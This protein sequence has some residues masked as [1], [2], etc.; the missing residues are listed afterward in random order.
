MIQVFSNKKQKPHHYGFMELDKGYDPYAVGFNPVE[1]SISDDGVNWRSMYDLPELEGIY[2]V[3][4]P[5]V[6]PAKQT[7]EYQKVGI[8]D[9][10]SLLSSSYDQREIQAK[11]SFHGIDAND[12]KLAFDVLQRFFVRRSCYWICFDSWP[13]RMYYVK[14]STIEQDSLT[15]Q[16]FAVTITFVD[17]IG[18][19]RSV[20]TTGD[21]DNRVVGFGNN[22]T[23]PE[24]YSF[25]TNNF[26]VDNL[27]DVLI[28]PERRGHPLKITV[29]GSSSGKFKLTNK[30]T[31]DSISRDKGFSGTFVL[32]GV[33]PTLNGQGD[34]LN[35]NYGIITLQIGSNNFQVENF[36]GTVKFDFPMWWLS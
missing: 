18:L 6:A 11:F 35:T 21:W 1:I 33:N 23:K 29:S 30:M 15:D 31:G 13:A 16:G 28:D 32:D 8:N 24:S 22:E 19:S 12:V 34:L 36:S 2:C 4:S 10:Q 20:G 5:W 27:S 7:D 25:N 17:Q 9:G 14:A 3:D 26:V